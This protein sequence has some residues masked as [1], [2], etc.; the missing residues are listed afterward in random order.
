[1]CEFFNAIHLEVE[2]QDLSLCTSI[3][4]LDIVKMLFAVLYQ[5]TY[6]I[7]RSLD[8]DL[9]YLFIFLT[10]LHSK[11]YHLHLKDEETK[12]QRK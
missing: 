12:A 11:N 6:F 10:T 4:L 5:F 8:K 9:H 2:L 7:F 3:S 1:M